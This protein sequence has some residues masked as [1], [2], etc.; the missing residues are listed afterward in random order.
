MGAMAYRGWPRDCLLNRLFGRRPKKLS[1]L[2]VT[3]FC[4][5]NSP[6][7][8]EFPAQR[9][10]YTENCSIWWRHHWPELC[11]HHNLALNGA[12]VSADTVLS[13]KF[14]L[15]YNT[16]SWILIISI[17]LPSTLPKVPEDHVKCANV[18]YARYLKRINFILSSCHSSIGL[19][20]DFVTLA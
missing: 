12:R 17:T 3:G 16:L 15:S 20:T 9:D 1:K 6:V 8:G 14:D 10:S 11:H 2:R 18:A 13:E 4:E 5:A 19:I 7:T